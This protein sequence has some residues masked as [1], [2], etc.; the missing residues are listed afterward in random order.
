MLTEVEM[1]CDSCY[2][3]CVINSS[4]NFCCMSCCIALAA[5]PFLWQFLDSHRS[6]AGL[7]RQAGTGASLRCQSV[8]NSGLE[9]TSQPS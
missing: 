3:G 8:N 1:T 4:H 7:L 9:P 5:V 6:Q 2:Q